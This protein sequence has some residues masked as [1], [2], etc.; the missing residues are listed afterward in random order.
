MKEHN[1]ELTAEAIRLPF[2]RE[3]REARL[4]EGFKL[5]SIEA[6]EGKSDP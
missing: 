6:Y 4:P 3:I 1:E 5:L 2:C